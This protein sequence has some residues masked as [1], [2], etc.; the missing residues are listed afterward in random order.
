MMNYKLCYG[1]SAKLAPIND[2]I[3]KFDDYLRD[4]CLNRNYKT[5]FA[6]YLFA[7]VLILPSVGFL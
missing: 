4:W 3:K 7:F 2:I 6:Y 1:L 5:L